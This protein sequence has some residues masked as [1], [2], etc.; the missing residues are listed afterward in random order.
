[1][2]YAIKLLQVALEYARRMPASWVFSLT[3][4]WYFESSV[5][6]HSLKTPLSSLA[7]ALEDAKRSTTSPSRLRDALEQA[8]LSRLKLQSM[9]FSSHVQEQDAVFNVHQP[10]SSVT[11]WFVSLGHNVQL[12]VKLE[13]G[14]E[15]ELFGNR[16]LF[17]QLV[18]ILINNGIKAGLTSNLIVVSL[19]VEQATLQ[20][21]VQDFGA[22]MSSSQ[23]LL[24]AMN[25]YTN[26][27]DGW[28]IGLSSARRI[29]TRFRGRLEIHSL[30]HVGTQI[31]CRL[32]LGRESDSQIR[33]PSQYRRQSHRASSA[34]DANRHR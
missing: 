21:V 13:R 23:V 31:I 7:L 24:C 15:L 6:A 26:Q 16:W 32:P 30:E 4:H 29:V 1:M 10:V 12:L 18:E 22:G 8:E 11:N 5:L 34:G 9:L 3:P 19:S 2:P 14:A 33:A 28:G 17:E 27:A 20:L 25:G